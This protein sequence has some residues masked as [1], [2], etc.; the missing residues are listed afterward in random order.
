MKK[1]I[2]VLLVLAILASMAFMIV[3]VSFGQKKQQPQPPAGTVTAELIDR[4]NRGVGLMGMFKYED[5]VD[6]FKD[7]TTEYPDALEAKVNLAVATLNRQQDGDEER[8]MTYVTEVLAEDP[9]HL[10]AHYVSGLLTLYAGEMEAAIGHFRF[11]AER[12]PLDAYA[13]YYV[14][15]C[16]FRDRQYDEAL[17]YLMQAIELDP[18]LRSAYYAASQVLPRIDREEEAREFSDAFQRLDS[19]PRARLV[20]FKYT[21]MGPKG[22]TVTI[23][24]DDSDSSRGIKPDGPTFMP[25]EPLIADAE[26]AWRAPDADQLRSMT[27]CDIDGD[28][29]VDIFMANALDDVDTPNAICLNDG[30]GNFSLHRDHRLAEIPGVNAML[31]GDVDNDGLTDVYVCRDGSNMLFRQEEGGAWVSITSAAN[32]ANGEFNTIDGAMVDADHDGDLDIFCVNADGPNE[33]FN[34]NLDGT[35]RPIAASQGIDGGDR[36]SRQVTFADLDADRDLDF[37]V[38]HDEAPHDVFL[39]D[40]LW[41]YKRSDALAAFAEADSIAMAVVDRD[42]DGQIELHVIDRT[43]EWHSWVQTPERWEMQP[44]LPAVSGGASGQPSMLTMDADGDGVFDVDVTRTSFGRSEIVLNP[45]AGPAVV[46]VN[47]DG[48]PW[49]QRP[50]TGRYP[51]MGLAFTGREDAGQSMRSNASGIGTS[52]AVRAHEHWTTASKLRAGTGPGQSLQPITVGLGGR[53]EADFIAIDWSDGVFQSEVDLAVGELHVIQEEQR[54]LSSCPVI[55]AWNGTS[56]AFVSD[57]LGVGGIGYAI[58]PGEYAEPRPWEN[59]MFPDGALQPVD[60]RYV[61]KLSEPM[62]EACYLDASALVAYDLPPGMHMTLDERMSIS[63]PVPTG[64]PVFGEIIIAPKNAFNERGEDVSTAVQDVD[65]VAAPI[66][67]LDHRFLG[68]LA[69][70]HVLTIEFDQPLDTVKQP[71]LVIDGWVEYP[72]SQ[73]M[74]SAWQA[75]ATYDAPTLE[76]R[77]ADGEW[78]AVLEQFGYPAGMPR[79]MSVPIPALPDGATALRLRTNLEVYWDRIVVMGASPGANVERH[80]F[81]LVAA[82]LRQTGFARRIAQPQRRPDYDYNDR[83]PFWDTRYQAGFYTQIGDCRDLLVRADDAQVIFGPGEEVHMEFATANAGSMPVLPDGWRRVLVLE[84]IGWCK[85]MDLFTRDGETIA[86]VPSRATLTSEADA[87]RSE[88]N[89]RFEAGKSSQF[90]AY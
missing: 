39:N 52:V 44:V 4:N 47:A 49:I 75:G 3:I 61:I 68:R 9:N 29:D 30:N 11:V 76:A 13:Q 16:L 36:A 31:W 62:E 45:N 22:G 19:N 23:G 66:P 20:E 55:F 84:S 38:L 90:N 88:F 58:G 5:A 51:F 42:A 14:G 54:Q 27:A 8:A 71:V 86:P 17:T 69:N 26:L 67:A 46:G 60:D 21:K 70:E 33:L 63:G 77:G 89:T 25:L 48:V 74:F 24:D 28:G 7:I 15:Q 40:R 81:E 72:Y 64:A 59:F 78:T 82:S 6:V 73:T 41:S 1:A 79:Q 2:L 85:D 87:L 56:F 10:R 35:F 18:Y 34:N 57:I 65:H 37:I 80:Q 50:G 12:D 83:Q 43:T 32:V 53:A